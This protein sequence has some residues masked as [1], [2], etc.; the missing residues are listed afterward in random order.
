MWELSDRRRQLSPKGA[1]I[2]RILSEMGGSR[3][4]SDLSISI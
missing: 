2:G 1:L 4:R 3:S